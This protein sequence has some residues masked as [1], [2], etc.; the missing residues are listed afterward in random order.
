M[1]RSFLILAIV[2][3]V[4]VGRCFGARLQSVEAHGNETGT[5]TSLWTLDDSLR[6]TGKPA[7]CDPALVKSGCKALSEADSETTC[8]VAEIAVKIASNSVSVRQFLEDIH[9]KVSPTESEVDVDC[10]ALCK[11]VVA[12][13]APKS[14]PPTSDVG[15]R[16]LRSKKSTVCDIDL[17]PQT[18]KDVNF[19]DKTPDFHSGHPIHPNDRP[20]TNEALA[21]EKAKRV[22]DRIAEA[23]K[24][25][26]KGTSLASVID[27]S[28]TY[29]DVVPSEAKLLIANLFRIYPL[30]TIDFVDEDDE[31]I[32]PEQQSKDSLLLLS[33]DAEAEVAG[34]SKRYC[35]DKHDCEY[36]DCAPCDFCK[37]MENYDYDDTPSR[38]RR[39]RYLEEEDYDGRRRR[40]TREK[41]KYI[42]VD[43]HDKYWYDD[44]EEINIKAQAY[45]AQAWREAPDDV[46]VLWK[47][48]GEDS[49]YARRQ[50]DKVL[51]SL[52]KMLSNVD[53]MLGDECEKSTYA[54]VYPEGP[55]SRTK[56]GRFI[57]FLCQVY[58]DSGKGEKIET[59]T[60]EGSHHATAFTDDVC[61]EDKHGECLEKAYGRDTC[62]WVA[63]HDPDKALENA[64]NYCYY[65]NDMHKYYK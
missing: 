31:E 52:G 14:L 22:A 10:M 34:C 55:E 28:A 15:C 18:M 56:K 35:R 53:Y 64:D 46:D 13:I 40:R 24:E 36:E 37:D 62:K 61:A 30:I 57:F 49:G 45:V 38:R 25:A 16:Y 17:S 42:E 65:I 11:G 33:E 50:V 5:V 43:P 12:S 19:D 9:V 59:I 54:Y 3:G 21:V 7:L 32:T 51:A 27:Y 2:L 39:R 44:V 20:A 8:S 41:S 1:A 4:C 26:E 23:Q 6:E 58:F 29:E 60:H 47:W 48:F 63:K